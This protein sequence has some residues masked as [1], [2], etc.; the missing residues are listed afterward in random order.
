M[1]EKRKDNKGRVLRAGES[2]RKNGSYC[3]RYTN[4]HKERKYVYAST[5]DELRKKE[6]SILRDSMDLIDYSRGAVPIAKCFEAWMKMQNGVRTNTMALYQFKLNLLNKYQFGQVPIKDVK[7]T[8]AKQFCVTLRDDGYSFGTITEVCMSLRTMCGAAVK[9]DILRKNPFCFQ[10][11]RVI[12]RDT[13]KVSALSNDEKEKLERFIQSSK[14]Y[15]RYYDDIIIL[16]DT[17]LRISEFCGLTADD[18]DLLNRRVTV[19]RQLLV[20]VHNN[21]YINPPK[22]ANGYRT[23]PLTPRAA[24]AFANVIMRRRQRQK[25]TEWIV[26]GVSGFLFLTN[27]GRPRTVDGYDNIFK[28]LSVQYEKYY[29][30]P[31]RITPHVLRHT[32]CTD[33]VA[34]GMDIKSLQYITGHADIDLLLTTYADARFDVAEASFKAAINA[35]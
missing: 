22:S 33:L 5:L 8:T 24:Q 31:I 13:K 18:V 1:S 7:E 23:I 12:P 4:M 19:S 27:T 34:S 10:L 9:D 14:V 30:E 16:L 32:F 20:D 21:L 11:K 17:G 35:Q 26:D 15:S 28:N 2:Q 25:H 29:G 6:E 3:Y